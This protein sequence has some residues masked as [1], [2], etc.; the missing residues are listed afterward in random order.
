MSDPLINKTLGRFKILSEI[1][2]GGMG[3]VYLAEHIFTHKKIAVKTILMGWLSDLNESERGEIE[4]RFRREAQAASQIGHENIG[5]IYDFDV[6]RENIPAYIAME[7]LTGESLEKLLERGERILF[8][9][10]FPLMV[11]IDEGMAEAHAKGLVHRDLKPANIMIIPSANT[12]KKEMVKI[13]DF[14]IARVF[15]SEMT[16][17]TKHGQL[18]GTPSHISP[19]QWSG[20]ET[21]ERAD[22]YALGL[23][24]YEMLSG[25]MPFR[26]N[27]LQGWASCHLYE[28]PRPMSEDVPAPLAKLIMQALDKNRDN[29]PKSA[30]VLK[31]KLVELQIQIQN[32]E[33]AAANLTISSLTKENANLRY[34][35]KSLN[36]IKNALSASL[37][38]VEVHATSHT[39]AVRKSNED[40]YLM[41]DISRAKA[42]TS[43]QDDGE[44]IIESQDFEIDEKGMVVAVADGMGALAGEVASTMAVETVSEKLVDEDPYETIPEDGGG[45]HYLIHKLH[46]ATIF[47]NQLIYQQAKSD[48]QFQ[49]MSANFTGIGLTPTAADLIQVGSSRAYL[50]RNSKI[51]Q[52]TKDQSLVQQLI[53]ARQISA[54][55]AETH[56]L[57]NV[58]LQSLGASNEIYPVSARMMLHR[59]DVFL[60]CSHGLSNKVSAAEMQNIVNSNMNELQKA[61]V[62]LVTQAMQK[63][64]E[65]NITVI[66]VKLVGNA[67]PEPASDQV[68]L[69]LIDFGDVADIEK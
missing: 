25:S 37:P 9:R 27:G 59:N 13:V 68:K 48:P 47:A 64:G 35:L 26:G 2:K 36:Q 16:R 22:V 31:D 10:A 67:F 6:A 49:G 62:E 28:K 66:L 34:Q 60:L 30:L 65:N 1:N 61:C 40:N 58:V 39:G 53:D 50:V 21:D 42:W 51:Y 8:Q 19:E 29:R 69:E 23:I 4:E 12:D 56:E 63:G 24:F 46:N 14:G 38:V 17:I 45:D 11:Q 33:Q 41:L 52:V 7:F 15:N 5:E 54:E 32:E 43:A 55:E 57:R 20:L 44:F 18:L 3:K